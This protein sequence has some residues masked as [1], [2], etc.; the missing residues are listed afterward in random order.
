MGGI[1]SDAEV[2]VTS[3]NSVY[4]LTRVS[5]LFANLD[6]N[7]MEDSEFK[8]AMENYA[9]GMATLVA[10]AGRIFLR[11]SRGNARKRILDSFIR[12]RK[13]SFVIYG[14]TPQR[15]L[16]LPNKTQINLGRISV[17]RSSR[18]I[19]LEL[20]RKNRQG[21]RFIGAGSTQGGGKNTDQW[22]RMDWHSLVGHS[23]A[24]RDWESGNYH[25]HIGKALK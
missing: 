2:L 7:L 12:N 5:Q 11:L 14:P 16:W 18:K 21:G 25:F 15:G 17:G 6:G 8:K 19:I 22:F 3:F 20:G 4:A 24:S 13:S 1:I 10:N 23:K 9:E